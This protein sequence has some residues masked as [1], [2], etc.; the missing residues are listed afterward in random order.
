MIFTGPTGTS[1]SSQTVT[2]ANLSPTSTTFASGRTTQDG[3]NWLIQAPANDTVIAG[4]PLQVVVT[5]R[6]DD[7]NALALE[8]AARQVFRYGKAVLR[9]TP[10]GPAADSLPSALRETLPHLRAD[11]AQAFVCAG[12]TCFRP[13]SD[14]GELAELLAAVGGGLGAAAV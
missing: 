11:Q 3:N 1:P 13:V 5:G 14:P 7:E 6:F 10:E 12:G 4:Q 8:R 9:L 2:I